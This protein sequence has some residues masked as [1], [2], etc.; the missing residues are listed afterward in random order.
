[1]PS[2]AVVTPTETTF[3]N[4]AAAAAIT[5]TT[6][7]MSSGYVSNASSLS[8]VSSVIPSLHEVSSVG[9]AG[10]TT[11]GSHTSAVNVTSLPAP[12]SE[13]KDAKTAAKP[14]KKE[15]L[16][17]IQLKRIEGSPEGPVVECSFD[18]YKNNRIIFKFGI[19]DDEPDEVSTN[20][21]SHFLIDR[22]KI[23]NMT[24][25]IALWDTDPTLTITDIAVPGNRVPGNRSYP[26]NSLQP[27]INVILLRLTVQ[28]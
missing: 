13:K 4:A 23:V 17:R 12:L 28:Q 26:N 27:I 9:S 19:D 21:V 18:T 14:G 2:S 8:S 3:T 5:E 22:H 7:S 16:P 20:M 15:R 24:R 6:A 10:F 11:S 1:M 25:S